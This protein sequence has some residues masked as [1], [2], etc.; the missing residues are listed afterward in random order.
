[1]GETGSS[2]V[3]AGAR[4]VRNID[5]E[6]IARR[7]VSKAKLAQ[8]PIKI[9]PGKYEVILEELAVSELVQWLGYIGFNAMRYQEGRS[10]FCG[11]L[12][13]KVMSSNITIWDDGLEKGGCPFPFDLEGVSKRKV[14]LVEN[15]IIK[16][17][18]YDYTTAKKENKES[19]GHASGMPTSGPMPFHLFMEGGD[20]TIE[21]MIGSTKKGILV[22]R[23][24]YI[25]IIDPMTLTITGT[26]RDGTFL[27]EEGKIVK[28]VKNLRFTQSILEAFS[29]VSE[30]STPIFIAS[31]ENY[32]IPFLFGAKV[33][34]V[35]IKE[36]NFTG[37][38]EH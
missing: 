13:K 36:W 9:E 26:T 4:D 18:V 25:N 27:I 10:P 14:M 7:A 11:K 24:W 23:L 6:E 28:A 19:T 34:A 21:D 8:N 22:T 1:M 30:L 15:G 38:T 20:S 32:G 2:R 17:L 16:G 37:V 35:K 5:C 3:E 29:K 31:S 33:P 12:G